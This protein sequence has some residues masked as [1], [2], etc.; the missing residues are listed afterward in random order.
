[1]RKIVYIFLFA[2]GFIISAC[3]TIKPKAY[4]IYGHVTQSEDWCSGM[5]PGPEYDEV[6]RN[7]PPYIGLK[8]YIKRGGINSESAKVYKTVT[9]DSLGNFKLFLYP[10]NYIIMR[11]EKLKKPAIPKDDP[12]SKWDSACIIKNWRD[13]DY[14]FTVNYKSNKKISFD[15]RQHCNWNQLCLDYTGPLPP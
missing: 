7:P 3:Y 8:L 10:G 13:G 6:Q 5:A 9:T 1:M 2:C 11:A 4:I 15:L 12:Y 14:K